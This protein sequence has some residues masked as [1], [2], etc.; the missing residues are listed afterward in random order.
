MQLKNGHANIIKAHH[1]KIL[2]LNKACD[3]LE[4]PQES[5]SSHLE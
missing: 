3:N 5:T 4:T 1:A 2:Q